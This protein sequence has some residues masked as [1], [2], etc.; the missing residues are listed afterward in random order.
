MRNSY[1]QI[2]DEVSGAVIAKYTLEEDFSM[3]T[4]VQVGSFYR[5]DGHFMFK[6]VGAGY[7]RGQ[8]TSCARTAA[9]SRLAAARPA[10][11]RRAGRRPTMTN[12]SDEPKRLEFDTTPERTPGRL[13]FD[14]PPAA[15]APVAR[16]RAAGAAGARLRAGARVR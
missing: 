7:N 5:R 14:A 13:A 8:A 9:R 16:G 2:A 6:A 12:P 1:I 15:A 3:E 4:S 10:G 11:Y